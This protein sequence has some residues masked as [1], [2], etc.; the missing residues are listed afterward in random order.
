MIDDLTRLQSELEQAQVKIGEME[1]RSGEIAERTVKQFERY[2]AELEQ[3]R[4]ELAEERKL[5]TDLLDK[6]AKELA[7]LRARIKERLDHYESL[8]SKGKGEWPN[9][10]YV[11]DSTWDS[12]HG[13]R[14]VLNSLWQAIKA[15]EGK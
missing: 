2:E 4:R 11:R 10:N 1:K 3:A 15:G 8:I 5:Y 13:A 14:C 6:R 9:N 12:W 7:D